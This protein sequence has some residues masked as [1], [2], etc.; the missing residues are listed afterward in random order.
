MRMMKKM[1]VTYPAGL[2]DIVVKTTATT[3]VTEL[4]GETGNVTESGDTGTDAVT[5]L[6]RNVGN[7]IVDV[8]RRLKKSARRGIGEGGSVK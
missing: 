1:I 2:I 7:A 3:T 4:I 6:K 8:R 5:K